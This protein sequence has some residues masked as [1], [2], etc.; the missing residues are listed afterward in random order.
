[1]RRK[2]PGK[3]YEGDTLVW[4]FAGPEE[5]SRYMSLRARKDRRWV[6]VVVLSV[7]TLGIVVGSF[8]LRASFLVAIASAAA[9]G[10]ELFRMHVERTYGLTDVRLKLRP[11][12]LTLTETYGRPGPLYDVRPIVMR[13]A[14][15]N[16]LNWV[17]AGCHVSSGDLLSQRV[18]L[19]NGLFAAEG[20]VDALQRWADEHGVPLEGVPP[21]VGGYL[22]PGEPAL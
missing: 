9:L 14:H 6:S 18:V 2:R 20:A 8:M 15:V 19:P 7:L 1:V 13:A 17:T 3:E 5:V 21:L 10:Y 22:R 11:G 4:R 12:M 16:G